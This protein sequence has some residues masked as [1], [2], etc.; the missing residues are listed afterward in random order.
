MLEELLWQKYWKQ[1]ENKQD[2]KASRFMKWNNCITR[3]L[4]TLYASN[5][6]ITKLWLEQLTKLEG[7]MCTQK[8]M[9]GEMK[10][11]SKP[12]HYIL[13]LNPKVPAT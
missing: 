1:L 3:R 11:N 7:S 5:A 10:D 4:Q 12:L 13:S 9:K 8:T 2:M 6:T